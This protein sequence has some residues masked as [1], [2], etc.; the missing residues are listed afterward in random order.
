MHSS[1]GEEWCRAVL[2]R[3]GVEKCWGR[4]VHSS[5]GEEW[6]RAVFGRSGVEKC[7]GTVVQSSVGEE[8]CR[9]VLGKSGVEKC[10]VASGLLLSDLLL[11][12]SCVLFEV[13]WH[14]HT[15]SG[16]GI[17]V[18]WLYQAFIYH[19]FKFQAIC[20]NSFPTRFR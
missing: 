13:V 6:C 8:W 18:R 12:L 14:W 20:T 9:E 2:G 3:S 4:L 1:V 5:V 15:W 7:W 10:C 16:Q 17:P 19:P 11:D